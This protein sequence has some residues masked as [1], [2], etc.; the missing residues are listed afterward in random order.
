MEVLPLQEYPG[1]HSPLQAPGLLVGAQ[2]AHSAVPGATADA[3]V[4]GGE[5]TYSTEGALGPG[6]GS[7]TS[8]QVVGALG[9]TQVLLLQQGLKVLSEA[10]FK[11]ITSSFLLFLS[12]VCIIVKLR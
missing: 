2:T 3:G 6:W 4:W 8:C 9:H 11:M 5:A 10:K 12:G 1:S 7:R